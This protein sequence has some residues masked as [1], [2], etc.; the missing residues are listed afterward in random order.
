MSL[1]KCPVTMSFGVAVRD[2]A[3]GTFDELKAR[4]D[5]GLYLQRMIMAEMLLF[6][7]CFRRGGFRC[8]SP[9]DRLDMK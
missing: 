1:E 5:K 8:V 7:F 9:Q 4:A 6:I 3:D 2:I